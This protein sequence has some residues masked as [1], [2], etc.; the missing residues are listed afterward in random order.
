M[1]PPLVVINCLLVLFII[2]AFLFI[3]TYKPGQG[4]RHSWPALPRGWLREDERHSWD[5]QHEGVIVVAGANRP[6]IDIGIGDGDGGLRSP[7]EAHVR[8]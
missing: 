6:G 2:A 4:G 8:S 3:T 7:P 1:E 5:G